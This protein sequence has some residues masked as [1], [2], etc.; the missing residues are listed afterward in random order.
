MKSKISDLRAGQ[1]AASEAAA[2]MMIKGHQFIHDYF[3]GF[4]FKD[5]SAEDLDIKLA[6]LEK[7]FIKEFQTPKF[8]SH[9]NQLQKKQKMKKREISKVYETTNYDAF[10][11]R[12]DNRPLDEKNVL[13]IMEGIAKIGQ[14]QPISINERGQVDDGQHRLEA[15]KRLGYPV[16]YFVNDVNLETEDLAELQSAQAKWS[17]ASYAHAFADNE[18]YTVYKEFSAT[19]PEFSHSLILLMLSNNKSERSMHMYESY[20]KG[21]IV[22]K[23]YRKAVQLAET[24]KMFAPYFPGYKKKSFVLAILHLIDNRDFDMDR[25]MRKLPRR[26]KSILDFS[27]SKDFIQVLQDVYNWKETKK[28]YFDREN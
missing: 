24:V 8:Q 17:T 5:I 9:N 12:K 27:K 6:E 28:V 11:K 13:T 26:C 7:D 22:I 1:K 18:D 16:K 15:C 3:Q 20:K 2:D 19:Y 23:S 25:M 14:V 4:N 10:A 21:K